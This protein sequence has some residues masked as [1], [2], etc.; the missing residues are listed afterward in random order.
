MLT[1][2][3]V[4]TV[5]RDV[6]A[7]VTSRHVVTRRGEALGDW[8]RVGLG[9]AVVTG[10]ERGHYASVVAYGHDEGGGPFA[11]VIGPDGRTY[12]LQLPGARPV[13]WVAVS[14]AIELAVEEVPPLYVVGGGVLGLPFE[15]SH[16]ADIEDLVRLW[17]VCGDE[18][19]QV[20]VLDSTGR[21]KVVDVAGGDPPEGEGLWLVADDLKSAPLAVG[22]GAVAAL[23]AG[24]LRGGQQP[25][26]EQ[27]WVSDY[28]GWQQVTVDPVPDKFTDIF[29][30]VFPLVAGHRDRQPVL[31]DQF[32]ARLDS[33]AVPLD[34]GHSQV[35]VASTGSD[36]VIL[37][38]QSAEAGPQL[39]LGRGGQ[40]AI[41]PLP[42]GRLRA[43]RITGDGHAWVAID[44][45][46]WHGTDLWLSADH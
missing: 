3:H 44:G 40:W 45:H 4:G 7:R 27:L 20:V 41:E 13:S 18:D 21:L 14:E 22:Q 33:P 30:G 26:G 31:F 24:K 15:V 32:G 39:W 38:L 34:P 25:P 46:L 36:R 6:D 12:R 10:L 43:A 28:D 11:A 2:C 37:A 1:L 17:P 9:S 23:V 29:S 42:P 19:P 16:D 8:Q 35:C 5:I